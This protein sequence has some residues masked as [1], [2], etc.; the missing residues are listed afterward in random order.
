MEGAAARPARLEDGAASIM[1]QGGFE[2]VTKGSRRCAKGKG[3][4]P[5]RMRG[6]PGGGPNALPEATLEVT[7]GQI[8]GFFS[9]L[10]YNCHQNRM[11]S[12]GD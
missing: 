2:M 11:A 3:A 12:V 9:Q 4:K 5:K 7:P 1:S 6:H 8:D 10:P